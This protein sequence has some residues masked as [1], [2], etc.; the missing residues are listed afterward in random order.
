MKDQA[1]MF[2]WVIVVTLQ[3][4]YLNLVGLN[5][6]GIWNYAMLLGALYFL[7]MRFTKKFKEN[8][9]TLLAAIIG[10]N[11]LGIGIFGIAQAQMILG[12]VA[13]L[14][15]LISFVTVYFIHKEHPEP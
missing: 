11:A 7:Y 8:Y 2:Y 15:A 1:I 14:F 10:L 5:S 12:A 9:E 13:I 4:F 3:I 6:F